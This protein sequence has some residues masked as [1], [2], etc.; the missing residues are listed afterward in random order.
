MR[1]AVVG[2]LLVSCGGD[3]NDAAPPPTC[4]PPYVAS[5]DGCVAK[6]DDCREDA[7][8][9]LGG[10]CTTIGVPRE[11]CSEGFAFDGAGGCE[12]VLPSAPCAKGT[13][14]IP[15]ETSCHAIACPTSPPAGDLYVDG[16]FSGAS[17]G[18]K[19]APYTTIG[20]ALA[21]ARSGAV[22]AIA[23]GRYNEALSVDK[24]ITLAGACAA[25]VVLTAPSTDAIL[26]TTAPIVVRDVSFA[27]GYTAI[28]E[29]SSGTA[30]ERVWIHDTASTAIEA[31]GQI[32]LRDALIEKVVREGVFALGA[33]VTIER[34]VIRDVASASD[35]KSGEGVRAELD[36]MGTKKQADV[37]IARSII[38]RATQAGVSC[39]ASR[40]RVDASVVRE[41]RAR[42]SDGKVGTGVYA[43][44][45]EPTMTIAE[46]TVS[47]SLIAENRRANVYALASKVTV[48]RSVLRDGKPRLSDS[49]YGLGLEATFGS[50]VTLR[51]SLVRN[52]LYGGV[53]VVGSRATIERVIVRD[54]SP[55]T[56]D[57]RG[58][59]G[60]VAWVDKELGRPAD[61]TVRD[62]R[63]ERCFGTGLY[64]GGSTA[65]ADGL[66][67]ASVSARDDLFGDGVTVTP[68]YG[69][70]I[71]ESS[72]AL[73]RAVVRD[74]ARSGLFVAGGALTVSDTS[75]LCSRLPMVVIATDV[76]NSAGETEVR[77]PSLV[78]GGHVG[79]G[80]GG[81]LAACRASTN[82]IEPMPPPEADR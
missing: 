10:G 12:P 76:L 30:L 41:T 23:A 75:L 11:A 73:K 35:K 78:D 28:A 33:K 63:I 79:C 2:V 56:S 52:N 61:L 32:T 66:V 47:G 16:S 22:I 39:L 69:A 6:L 54:T 14:A 74:S 34:S 72:L 59:A 67:V 82:T 20:A 19:S 27:G 71:H 42:V 51:D 53:H 40:V 65:V 60:V 37:T 57:G 24:P 3:A 64:V 77:A 48:E 1:A 18:S 55:A 29:E 81:T 36:A 5:T 50:D 46:V 7:V 13:Y 68:L 26:S 25:E 49:G 31:Y 8:P 45:H 80:C 17:D 38:E 44:A 21:A 43:S 9:A 62:V 58:G 70:Q 15:G 4:A